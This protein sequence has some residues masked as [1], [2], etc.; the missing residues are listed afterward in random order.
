MTTSSAFPE[1]DLQYHSKN[2][3]AKMEQELGGTMNRVT[4]IYHLGWSIWEGKSGLLISKMEQEAHLVNL[5]IFQA[6]QYLC[7]S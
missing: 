3:D 5:R 2:Q 1:P 6:Q 4:I 7:V